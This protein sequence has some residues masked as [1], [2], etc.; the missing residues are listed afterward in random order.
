MAYQFDFIGWK[1]KNVSFNQSSHA[2][3]IIWR[4]GE[5]KERIGKRKEE[6]EGGGKET[7]W[8]I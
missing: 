3:F 6:E 4:R 8:K 2:S 1:L 5:N 7:N